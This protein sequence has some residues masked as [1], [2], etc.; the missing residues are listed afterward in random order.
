MIQGCGILYS[1][2]WDSIIQEVCVLMVLGG[3][4]WMGC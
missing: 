4:F 3:A 1:G 2:R